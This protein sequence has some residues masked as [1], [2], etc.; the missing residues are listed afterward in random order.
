MGVLVSNPPLGW[1][2][3]RETRLSS[4]K[5]FSSVERLPVSIGILQRHLRASL[6]TS[7]GLLTIMMPPGQCRLAAQSST[8]PLPADAAAVVAPPIK[9]DI[10]TIR[11]SKLQDE[12][13]DYVAPRNGDSITYRNYPVAYMVMFSNDFHNINLAYDFPEWAKTVRYDLTAKVSPE[14]VDEYH[15]LD[16]AQRRAMFQQVLVDRLHLKFHRELRER[17]VFDLLVAKGGPKL[18][19]APSDKTYPDGLK[20]KYGQSIL[21]TGVGRLEAQGAPISDF[22][23][24]LSALNVGRPVIDKTSLKGKYDFTLKWSEQDENTMTPNASSLSPSDSGLSLF[25]AIEEQL[26]LKLQPSTGPVECFIVDHIER[27]TNN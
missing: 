5:V 25:T 26:G 16:K 1:S 6:I 13:L 21:R 8:P 3:V 9:F 2:S 10:V 14:D 20:E 27:P 12:K 15:K 19:Q 4:S 24:M 23:M 11:E 22:A 17:P 7:V 18:V